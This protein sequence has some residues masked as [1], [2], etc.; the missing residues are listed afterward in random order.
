[1]PAGCRV[2]L[3]LV[4]LPLFSAAPVRI[5][6]AKHPAV[7]VRLPPAIQVLKTVAV[8]PA[9]LV[10]TRTLRRS[11]FANLALR[12]C[13]FGRRDRPPGR[14]R[15]F[16]LR[17]RG[18]HPRQRPYPQAYRVRVR[19]QVRV[20]IRVRVRVRAPAGRP[21]RTRLR[22]RHRKHWPWVR[23][24]PSPT[25]LPGPTR[26]SLRRQI[27]R[28]PPVSIRAT[29]ETRSEKSPSHPG[30]TR[31]VFFRSTVQKNIRAR[32]TD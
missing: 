1:M 15:S 25:L 23:P 11:G 20:R 14:A 17:A 18:L 26:D 21:A 5:A 16:R 19:V 24:A 32:G 28:P 30:S 9:D 2:R 31:L 7:P 4:V 27:R 12:R 10:S 8:V 3:R 22:P 6:A 29:R 13:S